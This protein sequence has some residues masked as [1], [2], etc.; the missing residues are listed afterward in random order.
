MSHTNNNREAEIKLVMVD[1]SLV[2][3][4]CRIP[5]HEEVGQWLLEHDGTKI[6]GSI[7]PVGSPFS[8][9][10]PGKTVNGCYTHTVIRTIPEPIPTEEEKSGDEVTMNLLYAWANDGHPGSQSHSTLQ[11]ILEQHNKGK[12]N[13]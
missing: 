11:A 12:S 2:V 7:L 5:T 9:F 8:T 10:M 1:M 13:E 6:H 3:G 4:S